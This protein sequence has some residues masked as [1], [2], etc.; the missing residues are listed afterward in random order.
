MLFDRLVYHV[1]NTHFLWYVFFMSL[2]I[3]Q[4]GYIHKF[5]VLLCDDLKRESHKPYGPP[6]SVT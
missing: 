1:I 3:E 4:Q 2:G 5:S 6:I